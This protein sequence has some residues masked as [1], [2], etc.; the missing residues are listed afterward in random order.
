MTS[1]AE[2]RLVRLDG[3]TRHCRYRCTLELRS[4]LSPTH[5]GPSTELGPRLSPRLSP[6]PPPPF[7][8]ASVPP[9]PPPQQPG[10]EPDFGGGHAD[11]SSWL[12]QTSAAPP[13]EELAEYGIGPHPPL[14]S[15]RPPMAGRAPGLDP[16]AGA[17]APSD[18]VHDAPPPPL[19]VTRPAAS[20]A[21]AHA[22]APLELRQLWQRYLQ[23]TLVDDR[24][25]AL[26]LQQLEPVMVS[27]PPLEGFSTPRFDFDDIAPAAKR[28]KDAAP[29]S[30]LPA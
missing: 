26:S 20:H 16:G 10:K 13:H 4:P 24:V 25:I 2:V 28:S 30:L 14:L 8:F 18:G 21:H 22:H 17:D 3:D 19:E 27:V 5:A 6:P 12:H 1:H 23:H 9:P 7:P 15:A 29:G 11:L